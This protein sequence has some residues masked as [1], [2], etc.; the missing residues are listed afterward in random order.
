MPAKSKPLIETNPELCKDV[1]PSKNDGY[2]GTTWKA[3]TDI[4][5]WTCH[6]CEH[7]WPTP[8]NH[9]KNKGRG[10]PSCVGQTKE[11]LIE[12]NPELC[13][14]IDPSKNDGYDGTTWKA[15]TDIV[16][17]T[18]HICEH[19]WPTSINNRKNAGTGCPSCAGQAKQSIFET[20]PELCKDIDPS[21]NNG[22]DGTT[23]KGVLDIVNW[24]CHI[25]NYDWPTSISAR[26][27][28]GTGCPSCSSKAKQSLFETNPEL[29]KDIDPSKNDGYDGTTWK[30]Q[31][32][33]VNWT[34]HICEHDWPAPIK[35]RKCNGTGCPSCAGQCLVSKIRQFFSDILDL[36]DVLSPAEL[37][38]ISS[39]KGAI[40]G[41]LAP[42]I[43]SVAHGMI[44][45]EEVEKFI[46]KEDS[47]IDHEINKARVAN[48][49]LYKSKDESKDE[50][51]KDL[52]LIDISEENE[53]DNLFAD[54]PT[55]TAKKA[56]EAAGQIISIVDDEELC[57]SFINV[58]VGQIKNHANLDEEKAVRQVKEVYGDKNNTY[59]QAIAEKFLEDYNGAKAIEMPKGWNP[60]I[61]PHLMQRF[62]AYELKSG[63]VANFSDAGT[64]KTIASILSACVLNSNITLYVCPNRVIP[65][66]V[67]EINLVLPNAEISTKDFNPEFKDPNGRNFIIINYERFQAHDSTSKIK[68]LLDNH[69]IDFLVIDEVQFIKKRTKKESIRR[70]NLQALRVD[71]EKRNPNLVVHPM[72][73]TPVLNNYWE[74]RSLMDFISG[75]IHGDINTRMTVDNG[76]SI[77]F[78]FNRIGM[79]FK[80]DLRHIDMKVVNHMVDGSDHL[81]RISSLTINHNADIEAALTTIRAPKIA[82]IITG[83]TL[84][85]TEYVKGNI[86]PDLVQAIEKKGWEVGI[87]TGEDNSGL[88]KFE[89]GEIDVLIGSSC[90]STGV[91]GL[92]N[93]ANTMIYNCPP[94]THGGF[95][96][97]TSRIFRQ[98]QEKS[99]EIHIVKVTGL[100]Y[101]YNRWDLV[102]SKKTI[103]DLVLDG[104]IPEGKLPT[105]DVLLKGCKDQLKDLSEN[106]G[107]RTIERQKIEVEYAEDTVLTDKVDN[108][109]KRIPTIGDFSRMNRNWNHSKSSNTNKKLQNNPQEWHDYHKMYSEARKTWDTIPY[110]E[111]ITE[112]KKRK[113]KVIADFGCGEAK[114]AEALSDIHTVHSFDHVSIN[115]NVVACDMSK[116]NLDDNS[117]DHAVFSLSLM[118]C[119]F[120]DYILEAYRVLEVDGQIHIWESTS[121]F[122]DLDEFVKGLEIGFDVLSFNE[123]GKFTYIKAMK[124]APNKNVD[125]EFELKF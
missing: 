85:Y 73:A 71:A 105:P 121:R 75:L 94:W 35:N 59:A 50:L 70:T 79:R 110:E 102:R 88:K 80:K 113:G 72:S 19:D 15:Q 81:K 40:G 51:S 48:G 98:G 62:I 119:N 27:N 23:W 87:C 116:T 49:G 42:V 10:C 20:H 125:V 22:Y 9:R 43:K 7:D 78:H 60:N 58:R 36:I 64:G 108:G 123:R 63:N 1:D 3:Q 30:A 74:A 109:I 16:N 76:I 115:D 4:I 91:N 61:I 57:K 114:V 67:A 14:D 95:D 25:C 83:P 21:K 56:L 17:W 34:C 45:K 120:S 41:Y 106:G 100:D 12:T 24:T 124:K 18:C 89:N 77:Y 37:R 33:I 44:S 111:M 86:I 93:V 104:R 54:V 66:I 65:T 97:G 92:Q 46:N 52:T 29:C 11:S 6:I 118:G 38:K 84:V 96:Q 90:I 2:D 31:K 28:N 39:L 99:V 68:T 13:K 32:D 53:E 55:V 101:D 112:F 26:S 103:N 5:N 8:I 117:V 69:K 107:E 47:V 122:K 82:E